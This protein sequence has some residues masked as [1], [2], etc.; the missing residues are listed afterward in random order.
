ME[1][2][3]FVRA[4]VAAGIGA[5]AIGAE[6]K[7]MVQPSAKTG[8]ELYQLRKYTLRNGPQTALRSNSRR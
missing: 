3:E 2:R 5:G 8:Q 4:A 6:G 7:A 1:R